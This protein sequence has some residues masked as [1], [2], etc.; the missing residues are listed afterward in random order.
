M[1]TMQRCEVHGCGVVQEYVRTVTP[2]ATPHDAAHGAAQQPQGEVQQDHQ[3][4]P[5]RSLRFLSWCHEPQIDAL[6]DDA[7]QWTL[8]SGGTLAMPSHQAV[9]GIVL[10]TG[11]GTMYDWT[12]RQALIESGW[13]NL[14]VG[15][16]AAVDKQPERFFNLFGESEPIDSTA[17]RIAE[18]VDHYIADVAYTAEA[19]LSYARTHEPSLRDLPVVL[20]GF[21]RGAFAV[22]AIAARLED[23]VAAAVFITGGADVLDIALRSSMTEQTALRVRIQEESG[24]ER[25]LNARERALL[26]EAYR[27]ATHLDPYHTAGALHGIPT[28]MIHGMFDRIVPAST[29]H[30]L[31]ERLARPEKWSYPLGHGGVF[32]MLPGAAKRLIG[33]LDHAIAQEGIPPMGSAPVQRDAGVTAA[34]HSVQTPLTPAG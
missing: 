2:S 25:R 9:R 10:S 21:S 32:Y 12:V 13:A 14:H 34:P 20:I 22:P 28:L 3:A 11:G 23:M 5:M 8:Y 18:A 1:W 29:G 24:R 33:W 30:V 7:S 26:I 31:Y 17:S 16:C 19:F 15:E 4:R 6:S 27:E